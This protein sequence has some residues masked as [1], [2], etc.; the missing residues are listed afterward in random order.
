MK[1]KRKKY[2]II[3]IACALA[4]TTVTATGVLMQESISISKYSKMTQS[5]IE[6]NLSKEKASE[7]LKISSSIFENLN[8]K[9]TSDAIIT[10]SSVINER[11]NEIDERDIVKNICDENNNEFFRTTL[12]QSYSGNYS[13]KTDSQGNKVIMLLKDED[14]PSNLKQNILLYSN[15]RSSEEL[16]ILREACEDKD[17]LISY[18]A[19]KTLSSFDFNKALTISNNI[20]SNY[21]NEAVERVNIA[22]RI[23]SNSFK[24]NNTKVSADSEKEKADFITLCTEIINA[25]K[26]KKLSECAYTALVDMKDL[27]A[28]K[29]IIESDIF[30]DSQKTYAVSRNYS[31]LLNMPNSDEKTSLIADAAMHSPLFEFKKILEEG[32]SNP[33]IDQKKIVDALKNIEAYGMNANPKW[34]ND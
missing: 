32:K 21:K 11:I 25:E 20:L 14:T 22:L 33:S 30:S 16:E 18:Q 24:K 17:E 3:P 4:I 27:K 28:V 6:E 29:T 26:G 13:G 1:N 5:E 23:K 9:T 15:F 34:K 7:L 12:L 31:I 2:V 19:I 10:C 8:E